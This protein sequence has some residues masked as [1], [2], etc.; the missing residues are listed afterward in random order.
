MANYALGNRVDASYTL[1]TLT[2]IL[3]IRPEGNN[4]SHQARIREYFAKL[5]NGEASPFRKIPTLHLCR[6]VIVSDLPNQGFPSET[7]H[8]NSPYLLM[9]ANMA[10]DWKDCIRS[11]VQQM[12]VEIN[13]IFENCVGFPGTGNPSEFVDYVESCQMD[14]VFSFGAYTE[15]TL[16]EVHRA[17]DVQKRFRKFATEN[18]GVDPGDLQA[19]FRSFIEGLKTTKT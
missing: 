2:P 13:A 12:R 16:Y 11:M 19:N 5:P 8:L 1:M 7:D 4:P 15:A 9:V 14:S 10:G 3:N 6:F 17:L 18:Q